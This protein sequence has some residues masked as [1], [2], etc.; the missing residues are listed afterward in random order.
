MPRRL[1][2]PFRLTPGRRRVAHARQSQL[3]CHIQ[4]R[5]SCRLQCC[6]VELSWL[7]GTSRALCHA[8]SLVARLSYNMSQLVGARSARPAKHAGDVAYECGGGQRFFV[9]TRFLRAATV[10]VARDAFFW[11]A[12][13]AARA[14]I[15][16]CASL[17]ASLRRHRPP[18][19][20]CFLRGARSARCRRATNGRNDVRDLNSLAAEITRCDRC[21]IGIRGFD[22]LHSGSSQS[23]SVARHRLVSFQQRS[24]GHRSAAHRTVRK[25]RCTARTLRRWCDGV[26]MLRS[27]PVGTLCR[28]SLPASTPDFRS[29]RSARSVVRVRR[30]GNCGVAVPDSPP[31]GECRISRGGRIAEAGGRV[32]RERSQVD[33]GEQ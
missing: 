11:F 12:A 3:A 8:H 2:R 30:H 32:Q 28:C 23:Y 17:A 4:Q 1:H 19:L 18:L 33:L 6:L 24:T 9:A 31:V 21:L 7:R 29:I 14:L 10:F 25:V 5:A 16:F 27:P 15:R 20:R 26:G 13:R 22:N